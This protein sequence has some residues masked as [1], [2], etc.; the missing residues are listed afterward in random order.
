MRPFARPGGGQR[1]MTEAL[2]VLE[3]IRKRFGQREVLHDVSLTVR[4]GERVAL[5]GHNGAGK[6]TLLRVATGLLAADGGLAIIGGLPAAAGHREAKMLV[7]YLPDVPPLYEAL[8]PAEYLEYVAALWNI[9]SRVAT[10][11]AAGYLKQ[12]QLWEARHT[13]IQNLSKGMRQKVGL[14]SVFLR[15]PP[16]LL[17]D[18]PFSGLDAEAAELTVQLLRTW[19][20]D[21]A[22][23]V[24]SHDVELV[25]RLAE[26]AV[27]LRQGRMVADL[28]VRRGRLAT[29]LRQFAQGA[30]EVGP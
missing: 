7:G 17:L 10:E 24:A 30:A 8:T 12:Y 28:P 16:L 6:S 22:V 15:E 25:E 26:R 2:L 1:R 14:I 20:D 9:P 5:L 4:R 29:D 19:G 23:I 27:V 18:E 3:N 21:R 11:R 13:W